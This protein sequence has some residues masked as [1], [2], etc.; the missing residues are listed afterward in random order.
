MRLVAERTKVIT[1]M[2]NQIHSAKPY[3][4]GVKLL[5]DGAIGKIKAVHS[6]MDN[7]GNRY[8]NLSSRPK[9]KTAPPPKSLDWN[10]WLGPAP[11]RDFV[12]DIYAPF[13][14]RD[15]QDFGGG[16][17]G[18][19][20]CHILDPVFTALDLTAPATIHGE[21][22]GLHE[23]TWPK[24][25]TIAFVFPGTSF[26]VGKTLTITWYDGGRRPDRALAQVPDEKK[27][28]G[29]GSLFIGEK[30][31]MIL[32]HVG[33]PSLYPVEELGKVKMEEVPAVNHYHAWVDGALSGTRTTAGFHY[34]GPL[35]ETIQL[36]NIA[37]RCPG[38]TLEWNAETMKFKDSPEANQLLSKQ[39][40][41]GF[42]IRV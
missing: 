5:R 8:S 10:L 11:E 18:D 26:T 1:Q 21:N 16:T 23:E 2:G 41:K 37:T 34:A 40:R 38:K 22:D 3:R 28:P 33:M 14:W 20:G 27:L 7:P 35:T 29:A 39:Y 24:S 25:E 13:K 32:P 31:T 15:W 36:G 6:W 30:G 19:F 17:L 4:T 9:D 12:P 42:E